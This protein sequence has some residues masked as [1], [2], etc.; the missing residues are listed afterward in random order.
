[1]LAF[2]AGIWSFLVGCSGAGTAVQTVPA[3]PAWAN[4]SAIIGRDCAGCH[5]GSE[6]PA[7][8][9]GA[10]FRASPAKDELTSGGMPPPPNT[11]SDEDKQALL[12][13]LGP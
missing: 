10:V 2:F 7:F 9:S 6:E 8:T 13:Y 1:M 12:S 5:N 4:V 3:D 11:I